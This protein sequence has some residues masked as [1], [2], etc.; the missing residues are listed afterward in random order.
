[1]SD[2]SV[3]CVIISHYHDPRLFKRG[4]LTFVL[5]TV[6]KMTS[7]KAITVSHETRN[8]R[9]HALFQLSKYLYKSNRT[10]RDPLTERDVVRDV[11]ALIRNI[12]SA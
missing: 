10:S 12:M 7:K 5:H 6:A 4:R 8:K 11:L 1:M 2:E 3:V 9:E